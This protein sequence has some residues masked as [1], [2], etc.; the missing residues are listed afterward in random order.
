MFQGS[1]PERDRPLSSKTRRSVMPCQLV[2]MLP[3]VAAVADRRSSV[4]NVR[5]PR[6]RATQLRLQASRHTVSTGVRHSQHWC[7]TQSAH[8]HHTVSTCVT[9]SQHW[10]GIQS[11]HV[12]HT[13]STCVIHSQHLCDIQSALVWHTVS[14]CVIHSQ[15]M[16][17]IQSAL[18]W[19]TVSTCLTQGFIKKV[20]KVDTHARP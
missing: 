20:E 2:G 19:H 17:D 10:C 15:K 6:L 8:V 7:G 14:T 13:V 4:S 1:C 11:A 16:C 5:F 12:H 3:G 18:V 9:Y